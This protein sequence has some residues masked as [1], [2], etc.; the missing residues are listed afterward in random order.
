[1]PS[2]NEVKLD[3]YQKIL[4]SAG[5]VFVE[6]G[7]QNATVR[8]ICKRAEV[9]LAAIN[10]HFRDK[11]GLYVEVLRHWAQTA[12][13]KYPPDLGVEESDPPEAKLQAFIR[14]N[15]LRMLDE[16]QPSWF[17]KLVAREFSE[18]TRALDMLV[19]DFI[20]PSF[21]VLSS[22]VRSLL[23]S[24]A[25]DE[26]IRLYC[27]SIVG[28]CLHFYNAR[29]VIARLFHKDG[30]LPEEKE[31]IAEHICRFSLNAIQHMS[32]NQSGEKN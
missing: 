14:S 5:E 6:Y 11:E 31:Q 4:Q 12:M 7:F 30:Y 10:Y 26:T 16:G 9:N 23:G 13:E 1:M 8:D 21:V 32:K 24:H 22:I 20:R 28:Q 2:P 17:W 25:T 15:I 29:H 19:N 3:T 18:P 27:M